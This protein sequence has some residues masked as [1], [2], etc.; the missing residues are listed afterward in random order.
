MRSLLLC[1]PLVVSQAFGAASALACTCLPSKS[2]AEELKL[3][4]AVF[5]GKVVEIRRHRQGGETFGMVEAVLRVERVW[6]G[7]E[8][9]LVSVFTAPHSAGCGYGFREGRAYLVYAHEGADGRLS[10]SICS[11]TRRLR[12]AK[13]DMAELGPGRTRARRAPE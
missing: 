12:D 5:S 3:A 1:L 2:P 11:R 13:E 6:K 8:G 7:V 10:T 4:D 9:G